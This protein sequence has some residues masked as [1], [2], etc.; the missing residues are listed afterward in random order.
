MP[1]QNFQLVLQLPFSGDTADFDSFIE[2]EEEIENSNLSDVDVDGHDAG[3]GE[4]NIFVFTSDPR[5]AFQAIFGLSKV[6]KE[7]ERIRVAYRQL[8]DESERFTIL[9]PPNLEEFNVG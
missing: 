9:W 2:V 5:K 7:K 3:A 1:G 8:D 6:M 4:M